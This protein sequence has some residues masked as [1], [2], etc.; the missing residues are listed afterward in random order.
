M[1]TNFL[2]GAV[3]S[4]INLLTTE[5]NSLADGSG[6]AAGPEINNATGYQ[7]GRLH[8]H[9]GSSSLV[10]TAASAVEVHF[11]SSDAGS[12]YPSYTSGSSFK[13]SNNYLVAVMGINPSTPSAATL[14]EWIENVFIPLGKFKA[15]LVCRAGVTLPTGTTLDLYPTP[16]QY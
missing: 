16:S 8:L 4:V 10:F 13:L 3:G 11:L 14:D 5:L 1:A 2:W 9:I 12:T 7:V 15:V 6:S